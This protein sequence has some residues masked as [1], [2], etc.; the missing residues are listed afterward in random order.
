MR[1][2]IHILYW[3]RCSKLHIEILVQITDS[4]EINHQIRV[5]VV[6]NITITRFTILRIVVDFFDLIKFSQFTLYIFVYNTFPTKH[7]VYNNIVIS[8]GSILAYDNL[9]ISSNILQCTLYKCSFE[10]RL[11]FMKLN[12]IKYSYE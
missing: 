9:E 1:I 7:H 3:L 8:T 10:S 5:Y 6:P 4:R 12:S 2:T 11:N